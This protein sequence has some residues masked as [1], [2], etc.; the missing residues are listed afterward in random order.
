MNISLIALGLLTAASLAS[1]SSPPSGATKT[2]A[3]PAAL[4]VVI[5]DSQPP[6]APSALAA[7]AFA[8]HVQK[9]SSG[10]IEVEVQAA[11]RRAAA[12]HGDDLVISDLRSGNIQLATVPTR[13]WSDMGVHSAD[14]LQAPFEVTTNAHMAAVAADEP[15]ATAALSGLDAVGVHGL[16]LVPEGLRYI[17]G[18]GKPVVQPADLVGSFRTLSTSVGSIVADLGATPINPSDDEYA[19]LR[20]EGRVRATE[21][22]LGRAATTAS[23]TTA[24]TD[25][26]LYAKFVSVAANATWWSGLTQQQQGWLVAAAGAVRDDATS[27]MRPPA[28]DALAYCKGGGALL[29]VGTDAVSAFRKAL[30][31]RTEALDPD[32]LAL[33]R[34]DRP[35]TAEEPPAACTP[36]TDVLD[37]TNVR[38]VAGDL[39]N[40]VYRYR[41]TQAWAR[42]WNAT[43]NG[44]LFEGKDSP[45]NFKVITITWTLRDGHYTFA[46]AH[47]DNEPFT[48]DGVYQVAKDQM[49]LAL[50]PDIGNVV[51][52]LQWRVNSNGSITMTQ[53]DGLKQDPY[54]GIRWTRIGSA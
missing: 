8:E 12:N 25:L 41:W 13:A 48:V 39:P 52:R 16:G 53:V 35:A 46:I 34:A 26:V 30:E 22:D 20:T 15:L 27:T 28:D 42:T 4:H 49:L 21:T 51:N 1:C 32:K 29:R 43:S 11:G 18:F 31:A 36:S 33:L 19:N 23:G 50:A 38:P 6:S 2:G 14:V 40:G 7:R 44:I 17:V 24:S 54:Y 9:L 47:D 10:K 3:L 37:P 5:A 45:G